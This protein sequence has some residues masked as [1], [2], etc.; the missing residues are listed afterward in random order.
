MLV[1]FMPYGL[2]HLDLTALVQ[3][4]LHFFLLC[5]GKAL[6][7]CLFAKGCQL[8]IGRRV[9]GTDPTDKVVQLHF[10]EIHKRSFPILGLV[11]DQRCF[12]T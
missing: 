9:L 12:F 7:I 4:L 3:G 6:K 10:E 5:G 8:G 1:A 2:G 11:T